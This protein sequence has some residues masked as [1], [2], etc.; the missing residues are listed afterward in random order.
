MRVADIDKELTAYERMRADF[1]AHHMGEWVVLHDEKLVGVYPSFDAAAQ[2]A[3]ARFGRGP[4]LI[5]QVGAPPITL[6][7]SVAYF[8][9]GA[10]KVRV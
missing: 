2:D 5:K 1:E 9:H 8:Q 6:P 4:Y 10:D 3:V 7:A